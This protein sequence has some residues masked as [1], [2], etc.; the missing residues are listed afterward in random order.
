[1]ARP[2]FESHSRI[3]RS[4]R[5]LYGTAV[6]N[7]WGAQ[8]ELARILGTSR[9]RVNQIIREVESEG[10]DEHGEMIADIE[11]NRGRK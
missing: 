3:V 8:A 11:G 10:M 2:C 4:V 7:R 9:Q 5:S 1:M 6:L